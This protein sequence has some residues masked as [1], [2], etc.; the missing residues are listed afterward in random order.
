MYAKVIVPV[1]ANEIDDLGF[2]LADISRLTK[3]ADAIKDRIKA[4]KVDGI[5]GNLFRATVVK[6]DRTSYDPRKVEIMLGDKISMVEKVTAVTSVKLV[7][8]PSF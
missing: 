6:Q 3:Q 8:L 1:T 7:A 4:Q 2:L 5:D